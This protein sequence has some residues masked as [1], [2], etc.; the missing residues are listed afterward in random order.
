MIW[1]DKNEDMLNIS[2]F[3]EISIQSNPSRS[4]MNDI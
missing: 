4:S 1:L 3:H 2:W